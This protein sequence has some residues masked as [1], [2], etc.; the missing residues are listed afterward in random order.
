MCQMTR[1][2]QHISQTGML[3]WWRDDHT[4]R[5]KSGPTIRSPLVARQVIHRAHKEMNAGGINAIE[6]STFF[7][8]YITLTSGARRD[9]DMYVCLELYI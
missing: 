7:Y 8:R 1:G 4:Y 3:K 5:L 2:R 6:G 9:G